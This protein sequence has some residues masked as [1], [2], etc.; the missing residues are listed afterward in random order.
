[1]DE[2]LLEAWNQERIDFLGLEMKVL[3]DDW[4]CTDCGSEYFERLKGYGEGQ[5]FSSALRMDN[6]IF[7][8]N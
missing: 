2:E 5:N 1:M 8:F 7:N 3:V 4:F 6:E